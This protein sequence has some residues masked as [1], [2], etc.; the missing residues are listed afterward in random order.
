MSL[1]F[2][3]SRKIS[4]SEHED[5]ATPTSQQHEA[6]AVANHQAPGGNKQTTERQ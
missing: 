4:D 5:D 1:T 3:S 2:I 6:A